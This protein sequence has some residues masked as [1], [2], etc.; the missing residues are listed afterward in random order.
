[1]ECSNLNKSMC[2]EMFGGKID[3]TG[4]A[5]DPFESEKFQVK[6]YQ[7]WLHERNGR[8][9]APEKM[10]SFSRTKK[11]MHLSIRDVIQEALK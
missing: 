9:M 11:N 1:M 7:N 2:E 3:M 8:E 10:D 5:P 6:Y 4:K